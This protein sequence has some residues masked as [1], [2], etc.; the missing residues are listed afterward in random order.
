MHRGNIKNIDKQLCSQPNCVSQNP[1]FSLT[2]L[3]I[4]L[5]KQFNYTIGNSGCRRNFKDH[6]RILHHTSTFTYWNLQDRFIHHLSDSATAQLKHVIKVKNTEGEYALFSMMSHQSTHYIWH[7]RK[8]LDEEWG[9]NT[10][11]KAALTLL[12][13]LQAQLLPYTKPHVT[14]KWALTSV[15]CFA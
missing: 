10:M 5:Y 15:S 12:A 14:R 13:T 3:A 2:K 7:L 1:S 9:R 6:A 11:P 4:V 8:E